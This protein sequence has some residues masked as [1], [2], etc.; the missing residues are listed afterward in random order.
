[1]LRPILAAA[2]LWTPAP[3]QT[4]LVDAEEQR[5]RAQ[6]EAQTRQQLLEAPSVHLQPPVPA[7]E[8]RDLDLPVESPSFRI[9]RF[10][11]QVPESLPSAVR[12]QGASRGPG[13]PFRFAQRYLEQYAGQRVGPEGLKRILR[14]LTGQILARGYTT[15]RV[16]LPE[17]DLSGGTLTL[18][19]I[20][21]IIG[22]IRFADPETR[23]SWCTAFPARPGDL[24]N[25]RDLEQGLEQLKRVPSQDVAIAIVPGALVGESDVV[26]TFQQGK[27]WRVGFSVD[28]SGLPATGQWQGSTSLGWDNPLGCSDLLGVSLN[29]DLTTY[30]K[31]SGT[32]GGGLTYSVPYGYWTFSAA[33]NQSTYDQRLQGLQHDL[34]ASGITRN[35][36]VRCGYLLQ[37]GQSWKDL[38]QFRTGHRTSRSFLGDTE[39]EVQRRFNSFAELSLI[40]THYLGRA[41]LDVAGSLRRGVSWFGARPGPGADTPGGPAF[42]YQLQT[43]DITFSVPMTMGSYPLKYMATLRAQ[44][45]TDT[46]LASD[47]FTI[48]N[49]WTVRGLGD[50]APVSSDRGG[51]FRNDLEGPLGRRHAWYLGLDAGRV[52]GA[53]ATTPPGRTLAGLVVGLKGTLPLGVRF[54]LFAGGPLSRPVAPASPWLVA[55]FSASYQF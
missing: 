16:D 5:R 29:H 33:M 1:M 44:H 36:E 19:L 43:L 38:V 23:V 24:L 51:L 15:T 41:Q 48:G 37:R 22:N 14:R 18:D 35:L 20:P 42:R 34:T 12:A 49:R 2:L 47:A 53:Q 55:G 45:T 52:Q 32:K 26:L 4:P 50:G 3:G 39:I 46:L 30:R 27:T 9:D 28:D 21:G 13:A 11:L 25:L 40:H 10:F 31:G 7:E 54:N 6:E 8:G 17:Q